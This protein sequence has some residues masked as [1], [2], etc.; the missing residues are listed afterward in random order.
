MRFTSLMNHDIDWRILKVVILPLNGSKNLN[1]AVSL[2]DLLGQE[3]LLVWSQHQEWKEFPGRR[4]R[5]TEL[6]GAVFT[7]HL[8]ALWWLF[9]DSYSSFSLFISNCVS[10][11]K[12][13]WSYMGLSEKKVPQNPMVYYNVPSCS[14]LKGIFWG[15]PHFQTHPYLQESIHRLLFAVQAFCTRKKQAH[16][17]KVARCAAVFR[18]CAVMPHRGHWSK[19][20]VTIASGTSW[21]IMKTHE[22][23]GT[24]MN[25]QKKHQYCS[26]LLS[27]RQSCYHIMSH[28]CTCEPR[29]GMKQKGR[30]PFDSKTAISA[31][32]KPR[33]KNWIW[34][35]YMVG[36]KC[37]S[38]WNSH[39]LSLFMYHISYRY[40]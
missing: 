1:Q 40:T 39:K 2:A 5:L 25:F 16:P 6:S 34:L 22:T 21:K 20:Q 27:W 32:E 30:C 35:I 18:R 23:H 38:C 12:L 19:T 13:I 29:H 14:D 4:W 31:T 7:K 8:M 17:P 37:C 36:G 3:E 26:N 24:S 33:M 11:R 10:K 28:L 9:K 15:I